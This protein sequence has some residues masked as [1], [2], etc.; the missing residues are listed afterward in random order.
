MSPQSAWH[1]DYHGRYFHAQSVMAKTDHNTVNNDRSDIPCG[2]KKH[3]IFVF[4][5]VNKHHVKKGKSYFKT[6]TF[7]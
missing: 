4:T 2:T 6:K 5:K 1:C 3:E 7:Y